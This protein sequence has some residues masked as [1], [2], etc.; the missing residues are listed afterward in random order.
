MSNSPTELLLG[1]FVPKAIL[2]V[3][4]GSLCLEL[5]FI[6]AGIVQLM[7]NKTWRFSFRWSIYC[8][9]R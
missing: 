6:S 5:F 4:D 8:S 9:C 1:T 3:N 2:F 7:K